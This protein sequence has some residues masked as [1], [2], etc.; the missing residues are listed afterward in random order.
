M[1]RHEP[2]QL[3][4]DRRAERRET[5]VAVY[6]CGFFLCLGIVAA[7]VLIVADIV[8]LLFI[9]PILAAWR[10][11]PYGLVALAWLCCVCLCAFIISRKRL[12]S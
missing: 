1:H 8:D 11:H 3:Y 5:E 9:R 10:D 6:V 12:R 7:I 4:I 2:R